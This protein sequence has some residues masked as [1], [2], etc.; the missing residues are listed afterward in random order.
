MSSCPLPEATPRCPR[1]ARS[2]HPP[3]PFVP[4]RA[5]RFPSLRYSLPVD[6][7]TKD[8]P[9]RYD[10]ETY[11]AE[12]YRRR[13]VPI[14]PIQLSLR[15]SLVELAIDILRSPVENNFQLIAETPVYVLREWAVDTLNG[16]SEVKI[17][18]DVRNLM[19]QGGFDIFAEKDKL[20][21]TREPLSDEEYRD[22]IQDRLPE[23]FR[24]ELNERGNI[25]IRQIE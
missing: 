10:S 17:N 25:S 6:H 5:V 23:G 16:V 24:A 20:L 21:A 14:G 15:M 3:A 19:I 4:L 22:Y 13:R 7:A 1:L 2:K 11:L 18:N 9:R 12:S 8:N